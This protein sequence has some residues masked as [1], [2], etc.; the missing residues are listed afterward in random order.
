MAL[1]QL[2]NIQTP[3]PPPVR[4]SSSETMV[5]DLPPQS[6]ERPTEKLSD[7][8]GRNRNPQP[9]V[10]L[11]SGEEASNSVDYTNQKEEL[12]NILLNLETVLQS[13]DR[14][15]I[16]SRG[17][18]LLSQVRDFP[19]PNDV[20][21]EM[22]TRTSPYTVMFA[23]AAR[24][25]NLNRAGAPSGGKK[26]EYG[27]IEQGFSE[28][29]STQATLSY[30]GMLNGFSAEE[31]RETRAFIDMPFIRERIDKYKERR[32]K[33]REKIKS[34]FKGWRERIKERRAKA[35]GA[36]KED[37]QQDI[38]LTERQHREMEQDARRLSQHYA[39]EAAKY[40]P[41]SDE[42]KKYTL[43]SQE[44][45]QDAAVHHE[46]CDEC[47]TLK[48]DSTHEHNHINNHNHSA[49]GA[50][51]HAPTVQA[52]VETPKPPQQSHTEV[53]HQPHEE[54]SH[55]SNSIATLG[56]GKLVQDIDANEEQAIR[57]AQTRA[58]ASM[59]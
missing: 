41:N 43:L 26:Q 1:E 50:A 51:V 39:Q 42:Y 13:G 12:R 46:H 16:L 56:G 34:A 24:R 48:N 2:S 9:A 21:G 11:S 23:K 30:L 37:V 6:E 18:D 35:K 4:L 27:Y 32:A 14:H 44:Y 25:M 36:D 38:E 20:K 7:M 28:M 8:I 17:F 19:L 33:K 47:C 10:T 40:P 54:A 55:V 31:D 15:A 45:S 22:V 53:V 29:M 58:Q 59:V 3:P 57:E 5:V 52:R 49:E